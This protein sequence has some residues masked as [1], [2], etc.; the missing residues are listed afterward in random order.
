MTV[1]I[2]DRPQ[3]AHERLRRNL[4]RDVAEFKRK[5]NVIR[6]LPYLA[7]RAH[8]PTVRWCETRGRFVKRKRK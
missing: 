7:K 3:S 1:T 8:D 4:E 5:G 6:Q 2:N